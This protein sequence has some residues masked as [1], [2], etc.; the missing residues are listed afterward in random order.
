MVGFPW[1]LYF[2]GVMR[3]NLHKQP[4]EMFCKKIVLK[5]SAKST[6]KHLCLCLFFN[7]VASLRSTTLRKKRLWHWCFPV[8]FAKF[9][10]SSFVQ[11]TSDRLLPWTTASET[12]NTKRR[13]KVQEKNM[14]CKRALSFD[15]WKNFSKTYKPMRVWL[16]LVYKFTKNCQTY[17]LFSELIQTKKRYPTSL[18]KIRILTRKLPVI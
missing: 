8:N 9:L 15:Q 14:S 17:R 2:F 12:S 16:W 3:N 7:K 6:G 5:N 1:S 4:L 10:R 18:D 13:S 11:N